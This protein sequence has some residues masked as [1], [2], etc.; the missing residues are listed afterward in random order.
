MSD[1]AKHEAQ[2]KRAQKMQHFSVVHGA[3]LE[4]T[5]LGRVGLNISIFNPNQPDDCVTIQLT[6][7]DAYSFTSWLRIYTAKH[8]GPDHGKK[9]QKEKRGGN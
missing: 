9:V 8:R 5:D 4:V 2:A 7:M 1:E 6:P 3:K